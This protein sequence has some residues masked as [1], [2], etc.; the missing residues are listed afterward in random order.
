MAKKNE[1]AP[2]ETAFTP[3]VI[4]ADWETI[5]RNVAKMLEP[6]EGVTAETASMMNLTEAKACCADLRRISKELND[7]RKRI[8]AEYNKP[9]KEFEDRIKAIDARI[10]EPLE[11]IDEAVKIEQQR[12]RDMRYDI[13]RSAY[14]DYAPALAAAVDFDRIM[15]TQWLNKS[16]SEKKAISLMEEAVS[17]IAE[18][19][20]TFERIKGSLRFPEECEHTFWETLS[21]S[22]ATKRN[23]ALIEQAQ[24]L[25]AMK[26]EMPQQEQPEI[27]PMAEP[28]PACDPEP[29]EAGKTP[30]P[31]QEQAAEPRSVYVMVMEATEKDKDTLKS[32]LGGYGIHGR[33]L[34]TRFADTET[35][36]QAM[37]GAING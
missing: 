34:R 27:A 8:K 13:L 24:R 19:H 5:E 10:K 14:E 36:M 23:I 37:K 9:L 3:A 25:A 31:A 21:V 20:Q 18:E 11:V 35:A 12:E 32:V 30:A 26:A 22:E 17:G 2:I 4:T 15:Q 6:Y 33:V 28:K 16:M 29:A 1:L 7:G